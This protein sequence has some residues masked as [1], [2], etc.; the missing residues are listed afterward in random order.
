MLLYMHKTGVVSDIS[1]HLGS[2]KNLAKLLQPYLAA[3]HQSHQLGERG[4]QP[5]KPNQ[6]V[7]ATGK[8]AHITPN[9]VQRMFGGGMVEQT[10]QRLPPPCE[11]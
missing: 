8:K 1:P 6:P 11:Q 10:K 3:E 5:T 7:R 2:F 4:Q 9:L